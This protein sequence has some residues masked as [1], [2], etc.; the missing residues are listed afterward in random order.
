[1]SGT[2]DADTARAVEMFEH[3]GEAK[4]RAMLLQWTGITAFQARLWLA[5]IDAERERTRLAGE[6]AARAAEMALTQRATSAAERAAAASERSAKWT[7]AA[8]FA[9]AL[10]AIAAAVTAAWPWIATMWNL[11]GAPK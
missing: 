11:P 8:A 6:A 1:M 10:A 3:L 9:S 2:D 5:E 7:R 4:V